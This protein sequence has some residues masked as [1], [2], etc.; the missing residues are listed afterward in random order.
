MKTSTKFTIVTLLF[1]IPAFL[2]G[3]IIWPDPGVGAMIPT[4]GQLPFFMFISAIEALAFGIGIGFLIFG[5][6]MIK[7][8]L[9]E[10]KAGAAASFLSLSWLL[11]SWW[12][13]DNMHR[14]N[15]EDMAGLL[16]IEYIFHFTLIL[17]TFILV[18]Y[19]W[20]EIAKLKK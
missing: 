7:R 16:R 6:P 18:Y 15:G 8:I 17:V 13:H 14:A 12:P 20:K 9:P 10:E 4:A 1:G 2:L 19:F 5:F 11:V 3:R